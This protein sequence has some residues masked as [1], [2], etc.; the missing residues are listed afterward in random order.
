M[1]IERNEYLERLQAWRDRQI[2]KVVTGVRRCGKSVLLEMYAEWLRTQGVP[3]ERIVQVNLEDLDCEALCKTPALHS[4]VKER[5]SPSEMTYVFIDEVQL[6]EDFPRVVDSLYLRPNID[7]YITGSNANL[8][9]HELATLLSGRYVELRMLPL[10]L[11]EFAL[12]RPDIR[13]RQRLYQEYTS[14]SAFPYAAE[15]PGA[16][17]EL[18]DYL[19]GIYNTILVKD[20]LARR[21]I[22]DPMILGSVAK[23]V[24]S[25]IGSELS[26]KRIADTLTSSG[27]RTDGKTVER[28]LSALMECFVIYQAGR[29]DIKGKQLLKTQEKYYVV[30]IGL[31]RH[32]LGGHLQDAGH[33]LENVVYLELLRRGGKIRVGKIGALEVD[34]VVEKP[35]GTE[36]YQVAA[37]V[38][39]PATLERELAP[40]RKIQDS[41]PKF[42]LTLDEDPDDN[43]DGI[44]KLNALD[45]MLQ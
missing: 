35:D 31:R 10:S 19:E 14:T 36:Y 7:I 15:L 38:R 17:R 23:F 3:A 34:F 5:L 22:R 18:D 41:H 27:R 24:F 42:L 13:E 6:C 45:W 21:Q 44:R 33:I 9:S 29:Y 26:V 32:L 16:G 12:A 4:Y 20:V 30:D 1:R 40:F 2:I 37:S 39:D 11:R 43:I 8:L 25:S 28:Y